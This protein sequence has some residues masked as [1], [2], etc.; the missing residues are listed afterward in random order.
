MRPGNQF[1]NLSC[2]QIGNKGSIGVHPREFVAQ[3]WL[4]AILLASLAACGSPAPTPAGAKPKPDPTTTADY[5]EAVKRLTALDRTAEDAFKHGRSKEAAD[6]IN[7]GQPYQ[8]FVLAAPHPTLAAMQAAS[9]LD[10]LYAR[11]LLAGHRDGWARMFYQKNLARWR[12]WRP[13]SPE[14]AKRL[15]QAQDGIA[16]CDRRLS[17]IPAK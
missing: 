17:K 2:A 9:D 16:E 7:Q 5:A 11:M 1:S 6:A 10:D 15:R 3:V 4:V 13:E 12:T 14:S 8:G